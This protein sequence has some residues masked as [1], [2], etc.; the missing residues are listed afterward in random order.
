MSDDMVTVRFNLQD[1]PMKRVHPTPWTVYNGTVM[2]YFAYL[3]VAWWPEGSQ[4]PLPMEE[5]EPGTT[6]KFVQNGHPA[7]TPLAVEMRLPRRQLNLEVRIP[8]A[9]LDEGASR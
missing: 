8:Y 3:P 9:I 1:A 7:T 2:R 6:V 4:N 5:H